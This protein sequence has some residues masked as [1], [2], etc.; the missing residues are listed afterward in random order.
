MPETG[1]SR[2]RPILRPPRKPTFPRRKRYSSFIT[3]TEI[4]GKIHSEG[5]LVSKQA[6]LKLMLDKNLFM[7]KKV[8][9]RWI[10]TPY[11]ARLI[12]E[13]VKE[14]YGKKSLFDDPDNLL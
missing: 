14:W 3:I 6:F 8:G 4:I 7:M 9:R 2:I 13:L 11:E 12:V 1:T 10:A 5:C